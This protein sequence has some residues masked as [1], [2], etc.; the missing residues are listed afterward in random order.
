MGAQAFKE[1]AET[2]DKAFDRA[3][4]DVQN[5]IKKAKSS[6]QTAGEAVKEIAQHNGHSIPSFMDCW[7]AVTAEADG[8]KA[9]RQAQFQGFMSIIGS[10]FEN[11]TSKIGYGANSFSTDVRDIAGDMTKT[12]GVANLAKGAVAGVATLGVADYLQNSADEAA[13]KTMVLEDAS[14]KAAEGQE[15]AQTG[16][17]EMDV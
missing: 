8:K 13:D 6:F 7:K 11:V 1:Y 17:I 10:T 4:G 14:D 12:N 15:Q 2:Q 5:A 9:I 3:V 16:D